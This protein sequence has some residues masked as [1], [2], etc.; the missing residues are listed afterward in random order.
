MAF[1]KPPDKSQVEEVKAAQKKHGAFLVGSASVYITDLCA[2]KC[3]DLSQVQISNEEKMCL[4]NC[5]RGLHGVT[6]STLMFFRDFERQ[7]KTKQTELLR[8]LDEETRIEKEK[9][10]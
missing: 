3:L 5:V 2:P 7:A 1:V 9:N 6:E 10:S 4:K 8:E